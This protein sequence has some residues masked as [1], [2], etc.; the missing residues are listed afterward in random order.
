VTGHFNN[1]TNPDLA[2]ADQARNVISIFINNGSGAFSPQ[3]DHP[4][5]IEP[6]SIAVKD[7]DGNGR[8]DLAATNT[9]TNTLAVFLQ[10]Q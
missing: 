2:I 9:Q 4:A 10:V 7:L 6:L 1:D 5:G 8:D 3:I